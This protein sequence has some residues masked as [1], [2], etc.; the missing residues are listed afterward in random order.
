MSDATDP[1][2]LAERARHAAPPLHAPTARRAVVRKPLPRAAWLL[3][4]AAFLCGLAV[5][6]G[7]F[8]LGWRNQAQRGSSADAALAAQTAKVHKLTAS[9]TAARAASA[10]LETRLAAA[11]K[12][13]K[14]A[15]TSSQTVSS[16]ASALATS[17]VTAGRSSSSVS[18]GAASVGD[19]VDKIAGELKTLNAYLTTTPAAQLDPGYV[20]TQ[21]AYL[22]KQLSALQAARSDLSSAI[23]DFDAAAKKLADRAST[24]S[25]RD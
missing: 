6:A 14:A 13:T 7:V 8:S 11:Q 5:S 2:P 23:A 12:A 19:N 4:A 20:S 1:W 21:T 9:L 18:L 3:A 15:R 25:G 24:L 10:R 17:L 16:E 22:T